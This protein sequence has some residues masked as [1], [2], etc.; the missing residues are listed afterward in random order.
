MT[1]SNLKTNT[2]NKN[3]TNTQSDTIHPHA[4]THIHS[5]AKSNHSMLAAFLFCPPL[6][7]TLYDSVN[8][9]QNIQILNEN[10]TCIHYTHSQTLYLI[11]KIVLDAAKIS[12]AIWRCAFQTMYI[13]KSM[14]PINNRKMNGYICSTSETLQIPLRFCVQFLTDSLL[15]FFH[16]CSNKPKNNNSFSHSVHAFSI[17]CSLL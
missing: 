17:I 2:T 9:T 5:T 10:E 7:L 15:S 16:T 4:H 8:C 6:P 12:I 13:K 11:Y 14:L 1:H 3:H